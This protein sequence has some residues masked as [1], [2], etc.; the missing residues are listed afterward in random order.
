MKKC[1]T[2]GL[3][4][5]ASEFH[6]N[7]R[8]LDGLRDKCKPCASVYHRKHFE[9]NRK[10]YYDRAR[11]QKEYLLEVMAK[12]KSTPCIDCGI[13]YSP[14]IMQFDHVRGNKINNVAALVAKGSLR[15]LL[16]EIDKCDVVCSNCHANRTYLRRISTGDSSNR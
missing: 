9:T 14:W 11:K 10:Y 4:K 13:Q 2:C 5:D 7:R 12:K 8:N 16:E 3:T 15:K 6:K 1:A